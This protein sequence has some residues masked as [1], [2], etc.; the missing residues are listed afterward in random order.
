MDYYGRHRSQRYHWDIKQRSTALSNGSYCPKD[1]SCFSNV[2]APDFAKGLTMGPVDTPALSL[3]HVANMDD[4]I[5]PNDAR[6]EH[7]ALVKG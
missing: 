3:S 4:G 5:V 6:R 2:S 1:T 7:L